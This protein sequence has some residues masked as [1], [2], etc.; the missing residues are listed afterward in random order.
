MSPG[1]SGVRQANRERDLKAYQGLMNYQWARAGL[2]GLAGYILFS[3]KRRQ[4][5]LD[6]LSTHFTKRDPE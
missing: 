3:L 4:D 1:K 6:P 2:A 5:Q